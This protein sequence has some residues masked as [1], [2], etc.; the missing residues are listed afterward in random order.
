MSLA[1]SQP[2]GAP[3][4]QVPAQ[5]DQPL[6]RYTLDTSSSP[7]VAIPIGV[8]VKREPCP[9]IGV[10]S[11]GLAVLR[12]YWSKRIIGRRA[13]L[14]FG[15]AK[16]GT[17]GYRAAENKT[18]SSAP[19][20]TARVPIAIVS[21]FTTASS[22]VATTY[23]AP[24]WLA[25]AR[26]MITAAVICAAGVLIAVTAATRRRLIR[27]ARIRSVLSLGG[28]L[29]GNALRDVLRTLTCDPGLDVY[30]RLHSRAEYVT[31]NG[32]PAPWRSG[33]SPGP[34]RQL[35]GAGTVD[36]QG[37]TALVNA[38]APADRA[39]RTLRAV[40]EAATPALENARLQATLRRQVLDL[41]NSRSRTVRAFLAERRRLEGQ[42]HDGTQACLYEARSQVR[43]ARPHVSDPAA[44]TSID[45]AAATLGDAITELSTLVRGIYPAGLRETGLGSALFTATS[46]FPL[47][48]EIA[49][50]ADHGLDE[51]T[52][53]AG[54]FTVMDVLYIAA[55]SRARTATVRISAAGD[56]AQ[57]RIDYTP[58]A[59]LDVSSARRTVPGTDETDAWLAAEDRIHAMDGS[60]QITRAGAAVIVEVELPCAS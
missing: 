4:R 49:D 34:T 17:E 3:I 57:I 27:A 23:V 28:P 35:I 55:R 8:S 45:A 29:A 26:A 44:A 41:I 39:K 13:C 59:P 15:S 12:R 2:S 58:A 43:R 50:G 40:L 7:T 53:T 52:A 6:C 31:S 11:S 25:G 46:D 20:V 24:W 1:H 42:L 22:P 19:V 37:F 38:A 54:F 47:V 51:V 14:H 36:E 60:M 48:V 5:G 56:R 18:A 9:V 16:Y 10:Q 21:R 33:E 32:E 30:Y